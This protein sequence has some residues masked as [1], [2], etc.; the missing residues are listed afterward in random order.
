MV[1]MMR[2][3]L[4]KVSE[5]LMSRLLEFMTRVLLEYQIPIYHKDRKEDTLAI[6]DCIWRRNLNLK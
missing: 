5:T 2:V 4:A 3:L 6:I 1:V